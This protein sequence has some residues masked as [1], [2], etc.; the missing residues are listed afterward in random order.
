MKSSYD[1]FPAITVPAG[2]ECR[3]VAGWEAIGV[4]LRARC[5]TLGDRALPRCV[6]C[7]DLYHGVWEQEVLYALKKALRPDAVIETREANKTH[8][9]VRAM[10]AAD[11]GDDRVFAVMSHRRVEDY[12]D[13]AKVEIVKAKIAAARGVVLVYGVAAAVCCPECDIYVYADMARAAFP[14]GTARQL[15][16]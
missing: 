14:F 7:V 8:D 16:R 2:G 9:E 12:F 15:A 6:I 5:G 3:A 1:K 11:Q 10:L 4:E 13:P